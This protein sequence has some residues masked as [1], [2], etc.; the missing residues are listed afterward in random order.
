M[1]DVKLVLD[2][3]DRQGL[4]A[5]IVSAIADEKTNIKNVEAD[6]GGGEQRPDQGHPVGDG[7]AHMDRVIAGISRIQGVRR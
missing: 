1:F 3:E 7:Q 4:L 6:H 2:V 5:K